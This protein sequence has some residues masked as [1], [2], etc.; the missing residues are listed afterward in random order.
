MKFIPK[1]ATNDE[2][3]NAL[4]TWLVS[5]CSDNP[6]VIIQDESLLESEINGS[7]TQM[8]IETLKSLKVKKVTLLTSKADEKLLKQIKV[9][10]NV[11]FEV[12]KMKTTQDS[13]WISLGGKAFALN[14]MMREVFAGDE[15]MI[16]YLTTDEM[17]EI[18]TKASF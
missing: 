12:R 16:R 3:E 14:R 2:I 9:Q 18:M 11:D 5:I 7:F 10:T 6:N 8:F 1:N 17:L 15:T 13:V 4:Y